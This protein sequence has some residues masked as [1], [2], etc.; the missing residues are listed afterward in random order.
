MWLEYGGELERRQA[1]M[2]QGMRK[3]ADGDRLWVLSSQWQGDTNGIIL[4]STIL[5]TRKSTEG[6]NPLNNESKASFFIEAEHFLGSTE[7]LAH[8]I[9]GVL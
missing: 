3:K 2:H 6:T 4:E 7:R 9:V 8:Y 1:E 5:T